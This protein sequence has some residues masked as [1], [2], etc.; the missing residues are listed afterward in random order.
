LTGVNTAVIVTEP[1]LS[2]IHDMKR[3]LEV[4]SRFKIDTKVV[5]NKYDLN[6]DKTESIKSICRE[7]NVDLI[8]LIP[9]SRQVSE[10]IVKGVTIVE[11]MQN[12]V[13]KEI[14]SIWQKIC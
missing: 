10:S 14:T 12:D 7:E 4:A 1:T 13:S 11:Y 9:F 8:G 2:G 5:V 6:E 3:V